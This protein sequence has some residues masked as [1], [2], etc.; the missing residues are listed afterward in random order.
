M[1]PEESAATHSDAVGHDTAVM[2]LPPSTADVV[3]PCAGPVGSVEVITFPAVSPRTHNADVGQDAE[4]MEVATSTRECC[5]VASAASGVPV[6]S[7]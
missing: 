7:T 1:F 3:H 2:D 4:L 6:V 5:Q